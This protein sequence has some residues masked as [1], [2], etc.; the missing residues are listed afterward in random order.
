MEKIKIGINEFGR[1]GRLIFQL[2]IENGKFEVK[3]NALI[4]H[5]KEYRS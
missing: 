4:Q 2:A 1:I 5:M 3:N